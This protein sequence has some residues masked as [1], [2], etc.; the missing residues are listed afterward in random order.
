VWIVPRK[1][2]RREYSARTS[3]RARRL[4]TA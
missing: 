4:K 3:H 1:Y 2:L